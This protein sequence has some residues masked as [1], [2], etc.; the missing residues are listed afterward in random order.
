MC[1]EEVVR[2]VADTLGGKV[3]VRVP[4]NPAHRTAYQWKSGDRAYL[5]SLCQALLPFVRLNSKR[6]EME[7]IISG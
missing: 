3:Y 5:K 4:R 6:A 1:D 2:W 7:K